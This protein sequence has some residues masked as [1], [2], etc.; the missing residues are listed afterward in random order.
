MAGSQGC[1]DDEAR[2]L[3]GGCPGLSGGPV[4]VQ[5]SEGKGIQE[6]VRDGP[7]AHGAGVGAQCTAGLRGWNCPHPPRGPHLPVQPAR[8]RGPELQQLILP[9]GQES[10]M[11]A[12]AWTL[13][14][15]APWFWPGEAMGPLVPRC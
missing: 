3:G 13:R 11:R 1:R 8:M 14:R 12:L 4:S 5:A 15:T 6:V 7:A 2:L 10:R 9:T